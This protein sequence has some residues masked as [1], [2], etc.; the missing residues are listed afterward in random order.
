[1]NNTIE[2]AYGLVKDFQG[3]TFELVKKKNDEVTVTNR[4]YKECSIND[5][6]IA[7]RSKVVLGGFAELKDKELSFTSHDG[8]DTN[9][10]TLK[11]K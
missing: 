7:S 6:T 2:L 8:D 3:L 5:V 9:T 1:M 4:K 11:R 10:I